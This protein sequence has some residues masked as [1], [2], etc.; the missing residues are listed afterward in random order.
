MTRY[1][2]CVVAILQRK[3]RLMCETHSPVN[4]RR[5][6]EYVR[7][8][9]QLRQGSRSRPFGS[10]RGRNRQNRRRE[11]IDRSRRED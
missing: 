7:L 9:Q 10:L 4:P 11:A 3:E 8:T 1:A 2:S 5:G 6:E